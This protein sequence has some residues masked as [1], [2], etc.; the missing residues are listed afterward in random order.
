MDNKNFIYYPV[1]CQ[2]NKILG[3]K[4][5]T[6]EDMKKKGIPISKIFEKLNINRECCRLRILEPAIQLKNLDFSYNVDPEILKF[7]KEKIEES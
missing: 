6:I 5:E 3:D 4:Q 1:R 2:C 7:F